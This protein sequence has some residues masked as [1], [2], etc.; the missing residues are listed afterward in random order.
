MGPT[1]QRAGVSHF[2]PLGKMIETQVDGA[3]G[4]NYWFLVIPE[5]EWEYPEFDDCNPYERINW[6]IEHTE[7]CHLANF[8]YYNSSFG[9]T[10]QDKFMADLQWETKRDELLK[11]MVQNLAYPTRH[12]ALKAEYDALPVVHHL[13]EG[14]H[15]GFKT[16]DDALLYKLTWG[17][18]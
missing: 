10:A 18:K 8:E 2:M 11:R 1:G 12:A 4:F 6:A 15:I 14:L 16:K 17:G 13:S 9:I 5:E 3:D 7:V